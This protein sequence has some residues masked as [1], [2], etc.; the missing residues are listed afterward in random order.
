MPRSQFKFK[1][2]NLNYDRLDD[3]LKARIWRVVIY[4]AAILVVAVIVWCIHIFLMYWR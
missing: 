3:S 2:E 1:P 4:A